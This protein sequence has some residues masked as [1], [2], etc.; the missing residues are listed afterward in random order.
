[1]NLGKVL[2]G[3][4]AGVAAGALAGILFAPEK[5]S[6]TR[7]QILTKSEDYASALQG[8]FDELVETITNKYEETRDDAENFVVKGKTRFDE[9]KKDGKSMGV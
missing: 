6:K 4:L 9:I 1:M 3:L 2:L 7:K 8:K 5:G